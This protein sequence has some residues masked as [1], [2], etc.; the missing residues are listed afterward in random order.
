[1]RRWFSLLII[2][3]IAIILRFYQLG[4]N[5]PS[6]TWDEVAW[7]YNAYSLGIDSRDEFGRFLPLDYLESFGD[8]K[9]PMYAYLDILPVK[10]FGL[11]EF[12]VRFPSAFF[13]VL[14]VLLTYFLTRRIFPNVKQFSIFPALP[15]GRNFQFSIAEITAVIL[16]FSPWH[17][18]LSRAAFEANVATFFIVAGIWAF[19][20]GIQEKKWL[21]VISIISFIFSIYTFNTAR[22]VVPLLIILFGIFFKKELLESKKQTLV[23]IVVGI[24]L[25]L[26]IFQFLLTPQARLRFKEVNIF[27]D[28]NIIHRTN[29]EIANDNNSW[30]SKIIHNRRFAYSVEYLRHY[31]DHFNPSFLFIRGDGNPKF[32]TQD[33][34]QIY[35]WDLPFFV[36]GILLLFKKKE[37]YW[38]IIP[39][40]LLLGIVPAATARETPHALRIETT[41]PTFQIITAVGAFFIF[42]KISNLSI[43]SNLRYLIFFLLFSFFIFNF[44]YYLHGYYKHYPREYSSEWQYGYKEAINY[45]KSVKNDYDKIYFTDVLGRP[46]VYFLFY[47]KYDPNKF[48]NNSHVERDVFGFVTVN[49][50]DKY[51][52]NK[53][54]ISQGI[55]KNN[56]L[57]FDKPSAV[58]INASIKKIIYLLNAEETLVAYSL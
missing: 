58:P 19:L 39:L 13:G 17:I 34:G 53:K 15:A 20:A 43:L 55:N 50:F 29:Q 56:I 24:V 28:I 27:S 38:W 5:P 12:A 54:F 26:P 41:L 42:R 52:F 22:V 47:T 4:Q 18:N 32:S 36:I 46:Y 1:M 57:Y 51:I 9:P 37:R 2:I 33:V 8:F 10:I 3:V 6:L 7:G 48:R 35:L 44:L 31:F 16:A 25:M 45:I 21:L 14:T 49:S 11:N 30:W 40:W 23:A